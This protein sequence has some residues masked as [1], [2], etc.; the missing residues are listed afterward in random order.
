MSLKNWLNEP[1]DL[2]SDSGDSYWL[3]EFNTID[4]GLKEYL[5]TCVR[6]SYS[7]PEKIK[8]HLEHL[9]LKV[10]SDIIR[11]KI[12]KTSGTQKSEF[13]EILCRVT[14]EDCFSLVVPVCKLHHKTDS[15]SQVHGMDV[16]AFR[17]NENPE[18]DCLYLAEVKTAYSESYAEASPRDIKKK[19]EKPRRTDILEELGFII[20][21]LANGNQ[22]HYLRIISMLNV[23][24]RSSDI[25]LYLCPF[26]VQEKSYWKENNIE[27][28]R[29]ISFDNPI[30]LVVFIIDDLS[31]L[32]KEIYKLAVEAS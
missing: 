19:F 17:F 24:E 12:P 4:D 30:F 7:D 5:T 14:L 26:V 16:V 32:Y 9:N 22:D 11:L 21:H 25:N 20:D 28:I 27:R 15:E 10:L 29:N 23:Y 31:D 6:D 2:R 8:K 13:G 3:L 18:D 1:I